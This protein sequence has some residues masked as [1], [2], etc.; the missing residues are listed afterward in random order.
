MSDASDT[1][2]NSPLHGTDYQKTG[3]NLTSIDEFAALGD[4]R[5]TLQ[6]RG[7][8]PFLSDKYGLTQHPN[9]K[10]TSDFDKRN[11]FN[12]EKFL[13]R[14]MKLKKNGVFT[15]MGVNAL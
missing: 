2:G 9:C 5:R 8:R 10:Y 15:I 12:A 13:N 11:A 4:D 14:E 6:L 7:T 1:R 3:H